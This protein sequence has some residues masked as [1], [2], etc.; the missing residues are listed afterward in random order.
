MQTDIFIITIAIFITLLI[1]MCLLAKI[2][3][4]IRVALAKSKE[5][6]KLDAFITSSNPDLINTNMAGQGESVIVMPKSPQLVEFEEQETI[7]KMN[8]PQ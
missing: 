3:G 4:E 6:P 1:I 7:R 8:L 5:S 2:L